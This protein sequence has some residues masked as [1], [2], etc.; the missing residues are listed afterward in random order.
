MLPTGHKVLFENESVCVLEVQL[1]PGET[2]EMHPH[3]AHVVYTLNPSQVRHSFPDGTSR[4]VTD[5]EGDVI[6]SDGHTHELKNIG[7]TPRRVLV[8]ELKK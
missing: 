8:F 7:D 5:K 3:P 1:N 4:E 6:W 2:S